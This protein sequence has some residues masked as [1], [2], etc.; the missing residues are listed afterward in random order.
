MERREPRAVAED[1]AAAVVEGVEAGVDAAEADEVEDN[2]MDNRLL[3]CYFASTTV[4]SF[5]STLGFLA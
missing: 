2:N 4:A 1:V 5:V 3:R